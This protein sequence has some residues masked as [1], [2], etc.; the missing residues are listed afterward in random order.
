[1]YSSFVN[2]V[3][4]FVMI[5][6]YQNELE[7]VLIRYNSDHIKTLRYLNIKSQQFL[8]PLNFY[9]CII[10]TTVLAFPANCAM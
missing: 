10:P 7:T 1:M 3:I 2:F 8:C 6:L 9:C 5:V 4:N